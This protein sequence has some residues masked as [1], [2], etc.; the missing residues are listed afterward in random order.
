MQPHVG[1][2]RRAWRQDVENRGC[3]I[4]L[5]S[6]EVL[7]HASAQVA[8]RRRAV[9]RSDGGRAVDAESSGAA[10]GGGLGG[11]LL[12]RIRNAQGLSFS[13]SSEHLCAFDVSR[14]ELAHRVGDAACSRGMG[15]DVATRNCGMCDERI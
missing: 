4:R 6:R 9:Q 11:D 15:E 7:R 10:R 14:S 13:E 5:S 8:I 12:E 3:A 2:G 1:R